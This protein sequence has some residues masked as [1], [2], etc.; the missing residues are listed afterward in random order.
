MYKNLSTKTNVE[1]CSR[2]MFL[3]WFTLIHLND[4]VQEKK[5]AHFLSTNSDKLQQ[6]TSFWI[7]DEKAQY[8]SKRKKINNLFVFINLIF[9]VHSWWPWRSS[10]GEGKCVLRTQ[11]GWLKRPCDE[12]QAFICERDINRQ[13]IPL[14]VRCGNAQAP[15][16]STIITT[17]TM[18]TAASTRR[19]TVFVYSTSYCT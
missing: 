4:I 12:F 13:S 17:T 11:D 15:L 16:S 7:S 3:Y 9:K 19:P 1:Y 2:K 18:I 6:Q 14:T 5:L 10:S 8:N